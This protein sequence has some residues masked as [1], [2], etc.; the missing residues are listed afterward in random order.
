MKKLVVSW[1][2][3][4][5]VHNLAGIIARNPRDYEVVI[6]TRDD[7]TPMHWTDKLC[8]KAVYTQRMDDIFWVGKTL[9]VP[10]LSNMQINPLELDEEKL[11]AELQ[12]KIVFGGY[13][14]VYVQDNALLE[15]IFR[16]IKKKINISVAVFD[17]FEGLSDTY[18]LSDEEVERKRELLQLMHALPHYVLT[19][20]NE[21]RIY[22]I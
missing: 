14:E 10:K 3:Y 13:N 18:T 22:R 16:A 19:Y 20:D 8:K 12:M 17:R 9:G 5:W 11:I 4:T 1:D 2:T 6:V 7:Q 15:R 21:E